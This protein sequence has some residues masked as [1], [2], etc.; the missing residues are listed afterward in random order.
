MIKSNYHLSIVQQKR[1]RKARSEV[2]RSQW[3]Y[4]YIYIYIYIEKQSRMQRQRDAWKS[5]TRAIKSGHIRDGLRMC[6]CAPIDQK[7]L[8]LHLA[9]F[10]SA[11]INTKRRGGGR[12]YTCRSP[13][14]FHVIL[15]GYP[16][17]TSAPQLPALYESNAHAHTVQHTITRNWANSYGGGCICGPMVSPL[18]LSDA[19]FRS[20]FFK[21]DELA[22]RLSRFSN[23]FSTTDTRTAS[24][25]LAGRSGWDAQSQSRNNNNR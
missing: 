1:A 15:L 21:R 10:H 9:D 20:G 25:S 18:T 12:E 17:P 13:R 7:R 2:E 19:T 11:R 23:L 14:K 4:I 3:W 8:H 5:R 24:S 6:A 22:P 16:A